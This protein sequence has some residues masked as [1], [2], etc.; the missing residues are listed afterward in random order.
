MFSPLN[1]PSVD[2]WFQQFNAP[3][4]RLPVEE[5]AQLHTEVR[6][7][8]EALVVANEELGSSPEEAWVHAL[9]QFG[10]PRALGERLAH[11]WRESRVVPRLGWHAIGFGVGLH[12]VW[13][14][15]NALLEHFQ[16]K[17]DNSASA[18]TFLAYGSAILMSVAVG[19][20]YPTQAIKGAFYA[21]LFWYIALFCYVLPEITQHPGSLDVPKALLFGLIG[22][23]VNSVSAYL[24]SVTRR[25]WYRP[26]LSDFKLRLPRRRAVSRG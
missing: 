19:R 3:L 16:A 4:K 5:R 10:N 14:I 11:E 25:G 20:R 18:M 26:T 15:A 1:D 23:T 17:T 13:I 22:V 12:F 8:L 6:Q 2:Q 7:H 21:F 9:V 24:A